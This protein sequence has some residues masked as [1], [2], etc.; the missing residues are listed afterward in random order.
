MT[1][2]NKNPEQDHDQQFDHPLHPAP[3][4]YLNPDFLNSP[5]G[6]ILRIM[7]EYTEPLSR[8]RR[9]KIQDTVV[10][11]GSARFASL[12]QTEKALTTLEKPGSAKPEEQ[13]GGND[14]DALQT[15]LKRAHAAVE[16]S[17]YYEDARKLAHMLTE[18]TVTLPGKRHRFVAT[19]GG[20][21]GIME[22]ANR[23]A[24]E[25]GGKTIGLNIRLPFEQFPNPY[26]TPELNFEF[27][28]FFMRKYWFA[29]LA[30]A[31]VVFPGGFGTLDEL[32]EILTLAQ[33]QKLAKKI[34]VIVYGKEYWSRVLNLEA[35]ADAGAISPDDT[36][37]FSFCDSP[38]EAFE[39]LKEGLTK[40]HLQPPPARPV[41][42]EGPE[43]AKT[44]P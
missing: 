33:T 18:W 14:P 2:R 21:P 31:L 9:E 3:L 6:R 19:S 12:S 1:D 30:K 36:H 20:G 44:L 17:R 24:H 29:Y 43:I 22:A 26:I 28:Y 35:L 39:C 11:F 15:A 5:D 32:F 42:E 13:P 7:S 27:H 23:G 41:P 37:L 38:E 34:I 25:A 16:M 40:Y 4:A 8:F 10:F